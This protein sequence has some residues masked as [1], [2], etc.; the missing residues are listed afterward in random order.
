[1]QA[2]LSGIS[3]GT[4]L[5][6]RRSDF[7]PKGSTSYTVEILCDGLRMGSLSKATGSRYQEIDAIKVEVGAVIRCSRDD[8]D[9]YATLDKY[10]AVLPRVI[11]AR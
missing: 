10:Y 2:I 11:S 3:V 8:E 7:T 9:K 4:P 6:L 5:T 1:V